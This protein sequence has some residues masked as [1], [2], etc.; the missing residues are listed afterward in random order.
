MIPASASY[1]IGAGMAGIATGLAFFGAAFFFAAFFAAG[2]FAA[3]LAAGF[4]AAFLAA[5]FLATAF[6]A[7]GFLTTIL[8]TPSFDELVP[9]VNLSCR[10]IC[11]AEFGFNTLSKTTHAG[12]SDATKSLADAKGILA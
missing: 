6:L 3:F 5:G 2:F 10:R 4:F 11:D 7:A 8:M 9:E 1:I 12:G